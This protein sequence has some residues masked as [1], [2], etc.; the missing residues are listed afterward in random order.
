MAGRTTRAKGRRGQAEAANLLRERDWVVADLSAGVSTEDMIAS[1]P[2]G[3][4]W[5]VEVKNTVAILPEHAKQAMEQAKRRRLPWM[6]MNKLAGTRC[7]LVRR[8]GERPAVWESNGSH[9]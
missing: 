2:D 7:W 5:C 3:R 1:D 9:Q 6:L 8:Q 4:H